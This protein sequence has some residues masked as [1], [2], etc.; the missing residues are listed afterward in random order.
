M[1]FEIQS[2]C[3]KKLLTAK[4]YKFILLLSCVEQVG[5]TDQRILPC[6]GLKPKKARTVLTEMSTTL[7]NPPIGGKQSTLSMFFKPTP[8][9]CKGTVRN[10]YLAMHHSACRTAI[11]HLKVV[12]IGPNY[13]T[14]NLLEVF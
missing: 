10:N 4:T 2:C 14:L 11:Y 8:I 13:S 12:C 7:P 6:Y 9:L 5:S 3:L 1:A